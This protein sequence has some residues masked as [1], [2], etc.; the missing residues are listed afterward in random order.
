MIKEPQIRAMKKGSYLINY[1][2][3]KVVDIDALAA[4]I[5]CSVRSQPTTGV[6]CPSAVPRP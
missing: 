6:D 5:R 1:A 2:R 3:G 4:A